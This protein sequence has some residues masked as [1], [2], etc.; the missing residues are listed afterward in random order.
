MNP[1]QKNYLSANRIIRKIAPDKPQTILLTGE[2]GAGK[3]KSAKHILSFFGY[4]SLSDDIK[5]CCCAANTIFE[6]FGNAGTTF[7]KD[8]SRFTKL[9]EVY[10]QKNLN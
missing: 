8:S 3:T 6:S 2:S 7:N 10:N 1:F 9:T 5:K 4:E